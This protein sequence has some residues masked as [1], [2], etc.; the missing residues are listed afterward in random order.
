MATYIN[1]WDGTRWVNCPIKRFNGTSHQN[2]PTKKWDGHKWIQ[3]FPETIVSVTEKKTGGSA[4]NSYRPKWGN[5]KAGDAR[6]GNGT[7][8][9]GSNFYHGF[10]NFKNNRFT[11][12]GNIVSITS[13]KFTAKR[14]GSGYYNNDQ[15]IRMYRSNVVPNSNPQGSVTGLIT[16]TT[17]APGNGGTMSNRNISISGTNGTNLLN[18]M[19]G[20]SGKTELY[21]ASDSADEYLNITGPV[22]LEIKYAYKPTMATFVSLRSRPM[23][24]LAS[25]ALP[26]VSEDL[27]HPREVYHDML[28]YDNELNMTLNEIIEYRTENNIPD[29]K[30]EN[31]ILDF[32]FKPYNGEYNIVNNNLEIFLYYLNEYNIPEYSLDGTNYNNFKPGLEMEQYLGTLPQDF[33][34]YKDNI[35]VRIRNTNTDEIDFELL[36]E[37]NILIL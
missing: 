1:K 34:K 4:L 2:A 26:T 28:L 9:G 25:E 29:L 27:I 6:Q 32:D 13:A 21:I 10:L 15:T 5:W 17:G 33:N 12:A 35:H 19:N 11:G 3:I 30:L 22:T 36:V 31:Q 7:S 18:W 8:W 23:L 24:Y 16:T 37:P 20:I 14:G